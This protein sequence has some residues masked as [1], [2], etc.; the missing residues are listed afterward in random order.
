MDQIV[1]LNRH[2]LEQLLRAIESALHLRRRHQFFLSPRGQ[3]FSLIPHS[4]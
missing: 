1:I 4:T 2:E 3:F